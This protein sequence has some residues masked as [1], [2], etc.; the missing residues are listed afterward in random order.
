MRI[1]FNLIATGLKNNQLLFAER[2]VLR[3][4]RQHLLFDPVFYPVYVITFI[5]LV[6]MFNPVIIQNVIQRLYSNSYAFILIV[7]PCKK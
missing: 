7:N 1:S 4:E 2:K 5:F 3:K 6:S